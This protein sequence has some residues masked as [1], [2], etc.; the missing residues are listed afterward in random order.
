MTRPRGLTATA[1]FAALYNA[2]WYIRFH[3][4]GSGY[5]TVAP[6]VV[7]T[8]G[9][10]FAYFCLW[11]YLDGSNW[12][13]I[14]L[15]C[16]SVFAIQDVLPWSEPNV[17]PRALLAIHALFGAFLIWWLNTKRVRTFFRPDRE[18]SSASA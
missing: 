17:M 6:I 4:S 18:P 8:L 12:A 15:I 16:S 10:A 13:R 9:L 1:L 3:W 7:S 2:V 11:Y 14:L 5:N